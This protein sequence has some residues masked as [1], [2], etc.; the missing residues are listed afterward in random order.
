MF[1]S[2]SVYQKSI[3][4]FKE[5]YPFDSSYVH[6]PAIITSGLEWAITENLEDP[7]PEWQISALRY[8]QN[9]FA[10]GQA[11]NKGA[12]EFDLEVK[13]QVILDWIAKKI[14]FLSNNL[15]V[16]PKDKNRYSVYWNEAGEDLFKYLAEYY[17]GAKGSQKFINIFIFLSKTGRKKLPEIKFTFKAP[18]FKKM[19]D[20]SDYSVPI[21]KKTQRPIG[22]EIQY[23][24]LIQQYALWKQSKS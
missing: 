6:N 24:L 16:L 8:F 11:I 7:S 20:E 5:P 13:G 19:I 1:S 2:E 10:E 18:Q 12:K 3:L 17:E 14:D 15:I 23:E 9:K 22:W 4:R 21:W